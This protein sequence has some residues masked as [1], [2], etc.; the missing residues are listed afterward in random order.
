MYKRYRLYIKQACVTQNIQTDQNN[1][2]HWSDFMG[3][4]KQT[5]QLVRLITLWRG[6]EVLRNFQ[7]RLAKVP[8]LK[9]PFASSIFASA[10]TSCDWWCVL[11]DEGW[12]VR[13]RLQRRLRRQLAARVLQVAGVRPAPSRGTQFNRKIF[14]FLF[15]LKKWLE[16]PFWFCYI[17]KAGIFRR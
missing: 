8:F 16:I 7:F 11:S 13:S 1:Q 2:S 3:W 10:R 9:S 17:C 14:S 12:Q 5:I 15:S 4:L 6:E